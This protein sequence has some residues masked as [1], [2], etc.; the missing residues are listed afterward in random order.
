MELAK[1]GRGLQEREV[2]TTMLARFDGWAR[3]SA[4]RAGDS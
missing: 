4:V 1:A 3:S 2:A